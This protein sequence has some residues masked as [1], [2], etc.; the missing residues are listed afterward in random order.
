MVKDRKLILG[1][2]HIPYEK[3]LLGHSD[4]DALCHAVG[5]ALL[6]AAALGDI[7]QHFPDDDPQYAGISSL[8]L[9]KKIS[10]LLGEKRVKINNVDATIV[11]E[12]PRLR[13]FIDEM[14]K[15]IAEALSLPVERISIKAT[16]SEKMGFVGEKKGIAVYA[17][18]LVEEEH[19]DEKER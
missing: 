14:R 1:G 19:I 10:L 15:N 7:G 13:N 11:L 2:I 12:Q 6:G 17:C 16:T 5:D 18:A 9:L 3:G 8:L 4:A